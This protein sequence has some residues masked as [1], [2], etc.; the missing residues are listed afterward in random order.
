MA[1]IPHYSKTS[2]MGGT[3]PSPLLGY[4]HSLH[5]WFP[6][7]GH[8]C[9]LWPVL[10]SITL[11]SAANSSAGLR[12]L[13]LSPTQ[14]TLNLLY[15][16]PAALSPTNFSVAACHTKPT[17]CVQGFALCPPLLCRCPFPQGGFRTSQKRPRHLPLRHLTWILAV[18]RVTGPHLYGF[19][20]WTSWWEW[21]FCL[22]VFHA[23]MELA[24][25]RPLTDT[26]WIQEHMN[27]RRMHN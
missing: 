12:P 19:V 15:L 18:L 2:W 10:S 3:L 7:S 5:P 11:L 1:G 4:N 17:S 22:C 21:G 8:R 9:C 26:C 16:N 27:G 14:L 23:R 20:T 24:P 6:S 25:G 13:Q